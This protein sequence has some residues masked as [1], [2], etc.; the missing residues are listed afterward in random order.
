MNYIKLFSHVSVT[1]FFSFTLS[2][3]IIYSIADTLLFPAIEQPSKEVDE[4][5]N[6]Y[7]QA[8]YNGRMTVDHL[9]EVLKQFKDSQHKKEKVRTRI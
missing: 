9:L 4:K 8:I 7:F 2:N 6:A 5:A 1:W 3:S